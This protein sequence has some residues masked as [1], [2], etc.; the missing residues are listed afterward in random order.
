MGRLRTITRRTL[1]IGSAAI[2]GGVAFGGYMVART[3]ANPLE[4]D[5][6]EGAA[7]FNPWV[8]VD[9]EKVTLI[10]PHA[11][12]GQGVA[13]AQ[14]A[15]IAEEL[16]IEFGQFEIS[17][18]SP[19]DAYW[20]TAM[21]EESVPFKPTDERWIAQTMRD[22]AGGVIK[23]LGMQVTG[24]STAMPDSFDKLRRAGAV[25]RETLKAAASQ[26]S[27]V[28]VEQLRTANGAVVLPDESEIKYTELAT[29]AATLDV[30]TNVAL[31]PSSEWRLIGKPMQRL[32]IVAKSTGTQ[33][34]GVDLAVDGMVHAAICTNPRRGGVLNG[35]DAT[36]A[37]AMRGVSDVVEVTNGV[38]VIADNTWRAIRAMDAIAFD[39]GPAPY[40]AEQADHW[41]TLQ[42]SFTEERL[43]NIW[44]DDGDTEGALADGADFEAEYRSPYVAHAPLEP[45]NA[46]VL[47]VDDHVEVWAGHQSQSQL[48][49]EIGKVTGHETSQIT[50]HNQFIGGSFGHRLE[51]EFVKQAAEIANQMR[52][53]PIK[54]TY[55]REEDFAQDFPR[56][57]AIGRGR[58]KFEDG[59]VVAIDLELAAPSV[60]ASQY[61]RQG[62]SLPMP[63][64][65]LPAGA[66]NNP[67]A[68]PNYR[69]RTYR[70]PELV[71]VSTWR[72]V[73]APGAGFIFDTFLDELIHAAGADPL[74]ERIRL[75]E[76][77]VSRTVLET[78]GEMSDWGTP[79]EPNQAKGVAFIE[80][81]GVPMAEVIQITNTDRGIKVDKVWVACDVGT[82]VDPVNFENLVQG[83]VVFGLGHAMN[84]ELTISDGKI[85]ESNYH[86]HEA[87]RM[88][89][90]PEI[91]VRG[92][93]NGSKVRG[94]GEPP[95]PPAAPALG[96]AIFAATGQRIRALPFWN[97]IDFV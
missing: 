25:A 31:R 93:E 50:F 47:V 55:S 51:F 79:L 14:A 11:D 34:Y 65:I 90:C 68:F 9:S 44:R 54:L 72:S 84:C 52:G 85:Q 35:Y 7:T 76:H 41:R 78:V 95:V 22:V 83:G 73:G 57:P 13:S 94:I 92:L 33:P 63:D 19:A 58:G 75:M 8:L 82:I 71:P 49:V 77:D 88:Y 15:L 96:N 61:G 48:L 37:L 36:A 87:M 29:L 64:P 62:I 38:A 43:D 1:L 27:G 24:A 30:V 17:F 60:V 80:S 23:L 46:I 32:D 3:P 56:H 97:H 5:L 45:L 16:D 40:P 70:A 69:M 6:A 21:S 10:T 66:W 20:N 28:P 81:F 42:E 26:R 91:V 2:A 86:A 39:W 67:Y 59:K 74:E 4:D 89:Q 53:T 12:K 18:G